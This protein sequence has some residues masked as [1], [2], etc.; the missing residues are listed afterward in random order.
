M[1][2][3][4]VLERWAQ[5][6][7]DKPSLHFQGADITYAA[8]AH[9]A[10]RAAEGL[11]Q[12]L[13]VR[14]G[15]RVA[16][17]GYNRPQ[18]LVLLFALARIG[19]M[20]VPLN[21]RL[22]PDEHR[23]I[24]RHAEASVLVADQAMLGAAA[25]LRKSLAGMRGVALGAAPADW[26]GWDDLVAGGAPPLAQLGQ[27][28]DPVLLVYTSGTS[29]RPKGAVHTQEALIW[30]AVNAAHCHDLTSADHVLTVLPMFHVGGLCIQTLPALH[31]G[32]SV[33]LH[34]RFDPGHWI[35]DVRA[36]RPTLSLVVPATIKAILEHPAWPGADLSSLRAVFT[37]SSIVPDA[38]FAPFH[39]RGVPLAQV[40]GAT[41][42]GPVSIYLRAAD[43]VRKSGSAGTVA[44][45]CDI[46]LMGGDGADVARGQ[47][48]EIWVRGPSLMQGY[49]K[50][51]HNP[52]FEQG[53]FRSGDLARQDEEGFY[54]VAGR[55]QDMIVSG[56]ENIYPAEIENVLAQ[57]ADIA[58]AA[59]IGLPDPQ[60]GEVPV[61]AVVKRP[62]ST[63][64]EATVLRLFEGRLGRFK[65]PRRVVFMARL[66]KTALGKVQTAQLRSALER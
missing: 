20:L 7:P 9:D 14:P 2:L 51:P 38:L 1:S 33:T 52:A 40:Y 11:A 58:E 39:A 19:A 57:C 34:E 61:A 26:V 36:R 3:H 8:L 44:I 56:G 50:D 35:A 12:R 18:M 32:A 28:R 48:G 6:Q 37:G 43:A 64:D 45:H 13:G 59:V 47:V 46:R 31:A 60:W 17:L 29:G 42:T 66:P 5:I 24:L 53:W 22:A 41:E 55:S 54:W 49:W 25:E 16:Y 65:R 27:A 63:L 21:F 62:G 15:D 10:A 23:T 4:R 30:N